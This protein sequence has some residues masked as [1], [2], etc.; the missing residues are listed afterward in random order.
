[1]STI[2]LTNAIAAVRVRA[3]MV[4]SDF[5]DDADITRFLNE[6]AAELHDLIVSRFEDQ[7]TIVS[8]SL[9]VSSGNTIALSSLPAGSPFYKLRGVDWYDGSRWC[10][11][12]P[13]DFNRRNRKSSGGNCA[14]QYRLIGPYIHL[15]PSDAATGTYRVWYI[16]GFVDLATGSETYDFP[17][18]WHTYILAG[19]AVK[20]LAKEDSDT[21]DQLRSKEAT[22]Q[23]ILAMA[24]SRDAGTRMRIEDV[25]SA[26]IDADDC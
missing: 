11:V 19:A 13:F 5:V 6:E 8:S 4:G 23:R 20:C 9:T 26:D 22:R 25:R 2:T 3:D 17:Q 12:R 15:T 1:M 24:A 10:D 14:I 16:P 18:N 21:G 7:Y